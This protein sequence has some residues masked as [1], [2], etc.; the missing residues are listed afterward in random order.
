M[1][2]N[3]VVN[4]PEELELRLGSERQGSWS[5]SFSVATV[6]DSRCCP[7]QMTMFYNGRVCVSDVTD[8]QARAIIDGA[9]KAVDIVEE[10]F[11]FP[12]AAEGR[13]LIPGLSMKRSLRSFLQKRKER[14]ADDSR[15]YARR[16][17]LQLF[18]T[19]A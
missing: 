18:S 11:S 14:V 3:G 4:K 17:T 2:F 10:D 1:D 19:S 5:S 6:E 7:Q 13:L 8:C 9:K 16:P 12:V 15:P